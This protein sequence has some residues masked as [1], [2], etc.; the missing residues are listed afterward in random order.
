MWH[1]TYN[2]IL[3]LYSYSTTYCRVQNYLSWR[4]RKKVYFTCRIKVEGQYTT[5]SF[6]HESNVC[7]KRHIYYIYITYVHIS[8]K[9]I[10]VFNCDVSTLYSAVRVHYTQ[11]CTSTYLA[12]KQI[13]VRVYL[14]KNC[15]FRTNFFKMYTHR[16]DN[17]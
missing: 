7:T 9:N 13:T 5:N 11:C 12:S 2:V 8:I 16:E 4:I 17:K 15:S 6:L 14:S 10:C 1:C 3:S